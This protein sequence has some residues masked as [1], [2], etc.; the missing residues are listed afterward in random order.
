VRK[1]VDAWPLRVR[2][3]AEYDLKARTYDLGAECHDA[4]LGGEITVDLLHSAVEYVK[5]F[6]LG[7]SSRIA[8]KGRCDVSRGGGGG[9]GSFADRFDASFGFVIEAKRDIVGNGSD[10]SYSRDGS[11]RN[12]ITTVSSTA[13]GYD[14]RAEL[15]L[16]KARSLITPVPIRPRR[17]GERRSLRTFPGVS[18]RQ[19]LARFQSR[20]T[21]LDAF[22]LRF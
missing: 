18:L 20:H 8:L 21:S 9:G 3:Q 22:Q 2:V 6:D 15:P 4:L 1:R 17:R 10:G 13:K 16:S 19:P 11:Y 12:P 5:R 14:V 7:G